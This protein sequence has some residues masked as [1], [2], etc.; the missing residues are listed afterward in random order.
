MKD[1]IVDQVVNEFKQRSKVGVK[2]YGVTL[3]RTDLSNIQWMQHAK[4][5]AMDLACY[6]QKLINIENGKL[7]NAH[8]SK[9]SVIPEDLKSIM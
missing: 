5:E 1:S 9:N 2:K 8:N 4:E 7:K 6:L 3:D